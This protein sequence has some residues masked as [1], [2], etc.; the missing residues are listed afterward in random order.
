MVC[1]P[2]R[3]AGGEFAVKPCEVSWFSAL[4][5]D[6]YEFLGQPD[7]KLKSSFE[8]CRDIVLGAESGGFDNILL[9]SG[10]ALGIDSTAFAAAIA[11]LTRRIKLLLAVRVGEAWPP[12]LARQ[13]ATL[14]Q[15]AGGR[16]NI[17]IISSDIPGEVLAGKPRYARTLEVMQI[18]K[19]ILGGQPLDHH[20]EH[21]KLKLDPPGIAPVTGKCPPLYFG[22][23]SPD[24]RDA[25]A[26]AADVYL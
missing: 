23:L 9:P 24:A 22:G 3:L 19:A 15:I 18:L 16:L 10:Y 4:C 6:D 26:Q 8:H 5:D 17:N 2:C 11:V 21:Y 7:A 25:A 20:G 14:D 12:Q 13:I 1:D